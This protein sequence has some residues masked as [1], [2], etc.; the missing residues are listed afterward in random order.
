[1]VSIRGLDGSIHENFHQIV[2]KKRRCEHQ[3]VWF[4]V[5]YSLLQLVIE[6][7]NAVKAITLGQQSGGYHVFA[8]A[9][10]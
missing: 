1:M 9:Q 4:I 8:I 3:F 2:I 7:R 5:N 10:H 6:V